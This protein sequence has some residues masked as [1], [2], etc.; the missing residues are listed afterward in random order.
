MTGIHFEPRSLRAAGCRRV[1]GDGFSFIRGAKST[2]IGFRI[3]FDT[4][5]ADRSGNDHRFRQGIHEQTDADAHGMEVCDQRPQAVAVTQE[6]PAMVR[7]ERCRIIRHQRAL[8]GADGLRQF[9]Q[10]RLERVAFNIEFGVG[11]LFEQL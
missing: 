8:L 2:G 11:P 9:Q 1:P 6:V 3:Q 4:I 10:R 7:C 5:S